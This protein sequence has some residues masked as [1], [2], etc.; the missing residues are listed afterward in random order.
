[1]IPPPYLIDHFYQKLINY[2][3]LELTLAGLK[4]LDLQIFGELKTFFSKG[5]TIFFSRETGQIRTFFPYLWIE[6]VEG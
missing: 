1:L 3:L 6:L 2:K 5:Q 4:A